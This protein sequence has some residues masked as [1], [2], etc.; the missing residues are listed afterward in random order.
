MYEELIYCMGKGDQLKLGLL[1]QK[2]LM[3]DG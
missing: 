1:V 2:K 3:P